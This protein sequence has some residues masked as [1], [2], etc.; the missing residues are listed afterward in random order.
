MLVWQRAQK[1]AQRVWQAL[2]YASWR[3]CVTA[4][5]GDSKAYLYR[6]LTAA[7]IERELVPRS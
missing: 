3:E 5:F 4:E 1:P 6:Q 7:V 2:G